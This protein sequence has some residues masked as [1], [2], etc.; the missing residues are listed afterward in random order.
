MVEGS[1][2]R[3]KAKHN[4]KVADYSERRRFFEVAISRYY[5][6][7]YQNIIDYINMNSVENMITSGQGSHYKT[8]D[9]F[10]KYVSSKKNLDG[11]NLQIIS[12][13]QKLR[14]ARHSADY[15]DQIWSREIFEKDFK[16]VFTMVD[17]L[18]REE[19]QLW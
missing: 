7:L 16:E 17:N 9:V 12:M 15:S 4:Y 19:L 13:L 14:K 8:L 6:Y 5:Y 18:I 11:E 3:I 10:I 1:N 2:L